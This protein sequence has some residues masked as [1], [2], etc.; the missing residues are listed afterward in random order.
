MAKNGGSNFLIL[1]IVT[2]IS[3]TSVPSTTTLI[4]TTTSSAF[5]SVLP[6]SST[7]IETSSIAPQTT[8]STDVVPPTSELPPGDTTTIVV[9]PSHTTQTTVVTVTHSPDVP[10]D[11]FSTL[12]TTSS[13]TS[14]TTGGTATNTP[15]ITSDS[16]GLQGGALIAVAVIVPVVIIAVVAL[17][18]FLYFRKGKKNNRGPSIGGSAGIA[19][20]AGAAGGTAVAAQVGGH[21]GDVGY[22]MT[23]TDGAGYRGWGST[24]VGQKALVVNTAGTT[25]TGGKGASDGGYSNNPP[26]GNAAELYA[27]PNAAEIYTTPT[28]NAAELYSSPNMPTA[29]TFPVEAPDSSPTTLVT[30]PLL[31]RPTYSPARTET[32]IVGP[33]PTFD[34]NADAGLN[35]GASNASSN[36]S[37]ITAQSD[38]SDYDP[39]HTQQYY[40]GDGQGYDFEGQGLYYDDPSNPPP[41]I[42][43][44]QARRNT[45]IE[46]PTSA[47]FPQHGS[48]GI[49]QNF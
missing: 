5:T 25:G 20:A 42:R 47:H 23:E 46:T 15:K 34:S 26:Y 35:R 30:A 8:S 3:T 11:T 21:S 12:T 2:G 36:Y 24:A 39:R 27:T 49:A 6:P 28:S 31:E 37:A 45:R 48:S 9:V 16:G 10:T 33:M 32:S 40:A 41:V 14:T 18:I 44:V 29:S 1:G 43:D 7:S 13:I 17:G 22:E 38:Q 19:G 4:T